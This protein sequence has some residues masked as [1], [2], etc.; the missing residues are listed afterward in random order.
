M[1]DLTK[2]WVGIERELGGSAQLCV[3]AKFRNS[4]GRTISSVD[5]NANQLCPMASIAKIPIGMAVAKSIKQSGISITNTVHISSHTASPGPPKNSLDRLFFQP[6]TSDCQES[7]DRLLELAFVESDNTAA[8][9][10][11]K[12]LGGTQLVSHFLDSIGLKHVYV[13]R[14][15]SELLTYYYDLETINGKTLGAFRRVRRIANAAHRMMVPYECN[16]IK[17]ENLVANREDSCSPIAMTAL[18]EILWDEP[19]YRDIIQHMQNCRTGKNR[20]SAG[21]DEYISTLTMFAHKT[22]S[23]GGIAN[24]AGVIEFQ[25]GA[26]IF[27]SIMIWKSSAPLKRREEKIAEVTN[28]VIKSFETKSKC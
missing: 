3:S 19:V 5:F 27:L 18:L 26:I 10:L 16:L 17:E 24:D 2:Q 13:S 1:I 22:G 11:L 25:S 28:A 12:F 8:D 4:L 6:W 9:A 20:I 23:M 7:I 14:R 21:L 15:M